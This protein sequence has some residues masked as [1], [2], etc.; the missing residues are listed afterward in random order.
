M[1][2]NLPEVVSELWAKDKAKFAQCF[3]QP[4]ERDLTNR[5]VCSKVMNLVDA[6]ESP[7]IEWPAVIKVHF[8]PSN[9]DLEVL[10]G[11]KSA[12]ASQMRVFMEG[13]FW[14]H[15]GNKEHQSSIVPKRRVMNPVT[16]QEWLLSEDLDFD[17]TPVGEFLGLGFMGTYRGEIVLA[18][19]HVNPAVVYLF[20]EPEEVGDMSIHVQSQLAEE[21]EGGAAKIEFSVQLRVKW[22][23]DAAIHV[24][25]RQ[26]QYGS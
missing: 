18:T 24:I 8:P 9:D 13:Y 17:P 6:V 5:L 12:T 15:L 23:E 1:S 4:L 20:G 21:Y 16:Y 25:K 22:A 26:E 10:E 3:E 11:V 2:K 7:D 19:P 14:S